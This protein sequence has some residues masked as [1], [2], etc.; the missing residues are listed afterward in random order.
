MSKKRLVLATVIGV[1]AL[2]SVSLSISFAWYAS[3][4]KLN[5]NYIDI[6][7]DTDTNLLISTS[8]DISTFSSS[9]SYDDLDHNFGVFR[10]VSS[11]YKSRWMSEKKDKP[12]FFDSSFSVMNETGTVETPT[13]GG[14]YSQDL[15]LYTDDDYL[16]TIDPE[17][18][19]IDVDEEKI[20]EYA[21]KVYEEQSVVG[22][23]YTYEEIV[24]RLSMLK[25]A[26]RYSILVPDVD[27]YRYAI[28]NPNVNEEEVVFAGVLDNTSDKYYDYV[29]FNDG[30][31]K[32]ILYGEVNDRSLVIYD[33]PSSEES[34]YL[35]VDSEPSAFNA[36]HAPNVKTF[37]KEKSLENGLEFAKEEIYKLS[38]FNN[39][40]YTDFV[41]PV[42]RYTP[43]KIVLSIYIEGWD[44]DSVNYTMGATFISKLS[45]RIDRRM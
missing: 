25:Y 10:P 30:E 45:L 20:K 43:T 36:K 6:G 26:M 18:T 34:T 33:E 1:I 27:N 23:Q 15:Y 12:E 32:E 35:D 31:I 44:L 29:T 41:I 8:D 37:N 9:L 17:N 4:S 24:S 40:G 39:V 21:H 16:V 19:F 3:S 7:L 42:K 22:P 11:V 5:I 38:D 13:I 14:Y 28:I 2:S